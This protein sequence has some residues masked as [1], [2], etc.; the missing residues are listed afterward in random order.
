MIPTTS[1]TM[2]RNDEFSEPR[3]ATKEQRARVDEPLAML[4]SDWAT[5]HEMDKMMSRHG[6]HEVQPQQHIEENGSE[7]AETDT[8]DWHLIEMKVHNTEAL[9][10][11][12]K[13][14]LPSGKKDDAWI[15]C[16]MK[17]RI[18]LSKMWKGA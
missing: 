6:R 17:S 9:G 8:E 11:F 4:Y 18:A 2:D 7:D 14:P 15:A 10:E 16:D 3:L 5:F 13:L 1:F 12:S